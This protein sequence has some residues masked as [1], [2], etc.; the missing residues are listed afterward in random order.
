MYN[1]A[2]PRIRRRVHI[3]NTGFPT[4]TFFH[5]FPKMRNPN[6]KMK[7]RLLIFLGQ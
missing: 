6:R 4:H 5:H 2:F 1:N 7:T 3:D